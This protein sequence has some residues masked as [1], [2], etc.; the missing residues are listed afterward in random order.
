MHYKITVD[1]GRTWT[2]VPKDL[3][4]WIERQ[5]GFNNTMG[6]PNEPATSS[7]GNRGV[8]GK[9]FTPLP[10]SRT[11]Q[12][13]LIPADVHLIRDVNDDL[14]TEVVAAGRELWVRDIDDE[15]ATTDYLLEQWGPV[16]E[17]VS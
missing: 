12:K 9:M 11:W 1:D 13:A 4:V 16:T 3:Y 15:T 8:R 17:V 6:Q 5:C 14:W 2:E 10:Q 7:F